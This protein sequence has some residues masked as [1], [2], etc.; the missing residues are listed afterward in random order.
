[1]SDRGT[2]RERTDLAWQR[3]GL[4]ILGVAGL[5]AHRA[6]ISGRPAFVVAAGLVALTG[7][8]VLGLLAPSRHRQL[9]SDAG[10]APR[11]LGVVTGMVVLC[12]AV[13]AAAILTPR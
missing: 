9:T 1:M 12:A 11:S 4:G 3:T 13:A 6:L 5:L 10:V 8:A 2:A 7:L